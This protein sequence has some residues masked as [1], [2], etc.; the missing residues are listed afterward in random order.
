MKA[1]VAVAITTPTLAVGFP[2][3][4][5]SGKVTLTKGLAANITWTLGTASTLPVKIDIIKAADAADPKV[6]GTVTVAW[7]LD[8]AATDTAKVE[9]RRGRPTSSR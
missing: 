8:P 7:T 4:T 3:G 6:G 2:K 5:G 9:C 1:E